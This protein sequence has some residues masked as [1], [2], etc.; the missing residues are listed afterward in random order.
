M[1][2]S[3]KQLSLSEAFNVYNEFMVYHFPENE[4]KPWDM[5]ADLFSLR[6][7]I[8]F[9]LFE[10]YNSDIVYKSPVAYAF[11][12]K[13]SE[14]DNFCLLDYFAVKKQLRGNHIGTEFLKSLNS[15]L[16]SDK[17]I[18][19]EAENP[20]YSEENQKETAIKRINF[21]KNIGFS[22]SD[23]KSSII[24][25]HYN[26]L[27]SKLS[28]ENQVKRAYIEIYNQIKN[29]NIDINKLIQFE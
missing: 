26:L 22:D 16:F 29:P 15:G 13:S 8:F 3:I 21:Y 23:V 7:Y 20:I 25:V 14:K 4:L 2:Y 10:K 12:Q 27:C 9:G 11:F 24:G 19:V 28:D 1:N 6:K 5:I 18:I 17:T